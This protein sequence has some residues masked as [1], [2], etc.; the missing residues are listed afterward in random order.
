MISRLVADDRVPVHGDQRMTEAL[1]ESAVAR[2]KHEH[3][4]ERREVDDGFRQQ[5]GLRETQQ[6]RT[7]KRTKVR[8]RNGYRARLSCIV[9]VAGRLFY[10][11]CEIIVGNTFL[12]GSVECNVMEG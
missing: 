11:G 12:E 9:I 8:V 2:G 3:F 5:F 7:L 1:E 6:D 10:G 4:R